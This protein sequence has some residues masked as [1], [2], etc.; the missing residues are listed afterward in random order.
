MKNFQCLDLDGSE[1]INLGEH[2][3]LAG[4]NCLGCAVGVICALCGGCIACVFPPATAIALGASG[5]A[6]FSATVG[7]ATAVAVAG[8]KK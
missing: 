6:V 5:A 1:E 7:S 8:G 2:D 3:E 4:C